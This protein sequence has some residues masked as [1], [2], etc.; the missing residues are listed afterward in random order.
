M[1]SQLR[2]LLA[3]L[4]YNRQAYFS[5]SVLKHLV[6]YSWWKK[7][8]KSATEHTGQKLPP[9]ALLLFLMLFCFSWTHT[10]FWLGFWSYGL[11]S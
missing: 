9:A 11:P 6:F 8:K 5:K 10:T 4:Q 2:G 3:V 7:K 1:V